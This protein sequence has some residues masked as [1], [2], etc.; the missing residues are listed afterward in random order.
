MTVAFIPSSL[1]LTLPSHWEQVFQLSLL[2]LYCK[3]LALT[4]KNYVYL[5]AFLRN[6]VVILLALKRIAHK[7][8]CFDHC[9]VHEVIYLMNVATIKRAFASRF[10]LASGTLF[11]AV[12]TMPLKSLLFLSKTGYFKSTIKTQGPQ[13]L[14]EFI[15]F[16]HWHTSQTIVQSLQNADLLLAAMRVLQSCLLH[17][18][19]LYCIS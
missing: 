3:C 1:S 8:L 12:W 2:S 5:H 9:N 15:V 17:I 11:P 10:S 4:V 18:A 7:L 16:A 19:V 14:W 6:P 13:Y